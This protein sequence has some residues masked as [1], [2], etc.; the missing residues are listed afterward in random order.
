V[1]ISITVACGQSEYSIVLGHE[2]SGFNN[3]RKVRLYV[4]D[5][6]FELLTIFTKTHSSLLRHVRPKSVQTLARADPILKD[7]LS[8]RIHDGEGDEHICV[9]LRILRHIHR[10]KVDDLNRVCIE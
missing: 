5:S 9:D 7:C 4:L 1:V 3:I 8:C 2:G 6:T 10:K